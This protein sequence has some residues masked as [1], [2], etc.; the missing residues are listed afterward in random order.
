M[1]TDT[2]IDTLRREVLRFRDERDWKRFHTPKNL[3][4]GL[5][6]EAAELQELFL[7]K[8]DAGI[9]ELLRDERLRTRVGEE[10]ADVLVFLL[11][12]S[13]ACGVDLSDALRRKVRLNAEKYPVHRSY[14]SGA[15]YTEFE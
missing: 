13:D 15:K 6:I 14:G 5:S 2:T 9:G 12:L 8:D 11:Y 1:D 4:A 3:A 7:W 10:L